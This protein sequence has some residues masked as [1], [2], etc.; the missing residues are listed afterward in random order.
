MFADPVTQADDARAARKRFTTV[1]AKLALRGFVLRKI[2]DGTFVCTRWG[3]FRE[4]QNLDA[5]ERFAGL[6]GAA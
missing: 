4:L 1:Q 6:V 3:M 2:D 5:V